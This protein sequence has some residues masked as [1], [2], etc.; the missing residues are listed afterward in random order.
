[1]KAPT[2]ASEMK[3][4]REAVNAQQQQIQM[5]KDELS[6][7]D[8]AVQQ[9]QGQINQLQTTA[10]QAQ[11]TAQSAQSSSKQNEDALASLKTN[12]TTVET[13]ATATA[14]GL[15]SAEK[16]IK[17]LESP[18][19]IKYKGIK[20]TPGGFVAM[21]GLYRNHNTGSDATSNLGSFPL[22]DTTSN[23]HVP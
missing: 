21:Y 14:T 5:L 17:G 6:R 23:A 2:A 20:I 4:L 1:M 15:E 16:S 11:T 8:Q 3:T 7:R 9:M 22:Q 18:L 10:T 13:K 12:V 19:A